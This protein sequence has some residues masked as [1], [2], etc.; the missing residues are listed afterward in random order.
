MSLVKRLVMLVLAMATICLTCTQVFAQTVICGGDSIGISLQ[1]EGILITGTYSYTYHQET[2]DPINNDI[3]SGDLITHVNVNKVENISSLANLLQ[4]SVEKNSPIILTLKRNNQVIER[5]LSVNYDQATNTFKT[6]LYVKDSTIG[7]GTLTYY[8]PKN[9][10]FA[11]LGHALN[12]QQLDLQFSKGTV[13][14]SFVKDIVK[15]SSQKTGE[16]IAVVEGDKVLGEVVYNNEIGVYGYYYGTID[17]DERETATIEETTLG[18][19]YLLTVLEDKTIEKVEINITELKPQDE[20]A[21]KGICFEIVD[22]RFID[23]TNGVIQGMSGSPIVQN[24]K[25][26]GAVSHVN[27]KNQKIGYG[28]YIEWMLRVSQ[29]MKQ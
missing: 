27:G 7:I 19:A 13:F 12:D 22:K 3:H 11:S 15:N 8:D 18:P 17:G 6:G 14:E 5:S 29:Q 10:T 16:K 4:E 24:D 23:K 21:Q 9:N 26:I 20:L 2:I 1:Y 28:V 25:I